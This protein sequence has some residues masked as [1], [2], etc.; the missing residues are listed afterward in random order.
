MI[1]NTKTI[2]TTA[3]TV[4][5]ITTTT[6]SATTITIITTT[7]NKNIN[8]TINKNN[9][10]INLSHSNHNNATDSNVTISHYDDIQLLM[11]VMI[12]MRLDMILKREPQKP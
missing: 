6:I 12:I 4:T 1:Q 3:I 8:K 5:T 2:T 10:K 11:N 7:K 9:I